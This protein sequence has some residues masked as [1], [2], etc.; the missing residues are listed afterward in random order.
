MTPMRTVRGVIPAWPALLDVDI[1]SFDPPEIL[2]APAK[3]GHAEL[4]FRVI[5][6]QPSNQHA[7]ATHPVDLLPAC[8][9]RPRSGRAAEQRDELA[10]SHVGHGPFI[11]P[12]S[13]HPQ[14]RTDIARPARR[15]THVRSVD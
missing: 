14:R 1:A 13:H 4:A 12:R 9:E 11:L 2:Q 3:G 7:D 10:A 15:N 8:R 5:L 6:C